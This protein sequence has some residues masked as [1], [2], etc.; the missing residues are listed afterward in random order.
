MYFLQGS[1]VSGIMAFLPIAAA[2]QPLRF[3][4]N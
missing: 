2:Q 4:G 3:A 1:F